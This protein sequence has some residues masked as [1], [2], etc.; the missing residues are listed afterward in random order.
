MC[1]ENCETCSGGQSSQC[2][3]CKEQF[4]LKG[5]ACECPEG[6]YQKG[7][8]CVSLAQQT[9]SSLLQQTSDPAQYKLILTNF[10]D[11][12]LSTIAGS[13]D[14]AIQ[15][16]EFLTDYNFT[17]SKAQVVRQTTVLFNF[18]FQSSV[19]EGPWLFVQLL[20]FQGPESVK[21]LQVK[22]QSYLK[23]S[24]T[25]AESIQSISDTSASAAS[26][27]GT[28]TESS[29]LLSGGSSSSAA[30]AM[31]L[32]LITIMHYT[33]LS[34]PL[35]YPSTLGYSS[36]FAFQ[37]LQMAEDEKKR[38]RMPA[39]F[40][41]LKISNN[42]WNNLSGLI[43]QSIVYSVAA[44]A[45]LGANKVLV[46]VCNTNVAL[47]QTIV[48]TFLYNQIIFIFYGNGIFLVFFIINQIQYYPV[49]AINSVQSVQNIFAIMF[50]TCFYTGLVILYRIEDKITRQIK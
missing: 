22:M 2:L 5:G 10:E 31:S 6:S 48:N 8:Q 11:D 9:Y 30:N 50:L 36:S 33:N 17:L 23:M 7:A 24:Q 32:Q 35:N 44:C 46:Q 29:S 42:L 45:L 20:N 12:Y 14:V 49:D 40:Q 37:S 4:A 26:S 39:K 38:E 41:K 19:T 3:S 1:S 25:E 27:A 34:F 15:N 16:L 43:V 47:I 28:A 18:T 13:L 21:F